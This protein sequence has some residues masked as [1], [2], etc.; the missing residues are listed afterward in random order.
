VESFIPYFGCGSR[1]LK[2]EST[3]DFRCRKYEDLIEKKI[4]PYL[5]NHKVEGDKNNSLSDVKLQK[6]YKQNNI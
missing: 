6:F 2:G 3:I 4:I 1:N 5:N